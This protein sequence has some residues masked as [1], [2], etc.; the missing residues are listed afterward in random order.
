MLPQPDTQPSPRA[1]VS[2]WREVLNRIEALRKKEGFS[3]EAA[4]VKVGVAYSTYYQW[5]RRAERGKQ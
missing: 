3:L 1:R 4:C 2:N 5:K